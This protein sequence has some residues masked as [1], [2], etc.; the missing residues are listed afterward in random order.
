MKPERWQQVKDLFSRALD[1]DEGERAAFVAAEAADDEDLQ[2]EVLR[3]LEEERRSAEFLTPPNV[4]ESLPDFGPG[5]REIPADLEQLGDF[6]LL[7]EIG[8]GGNGVVYLARQE[9]LGRMVAVKILWPAM[10]FSRHQMERFRREAIATAKLQHPGIVQ[11]HMVGEDRD[12]PYLVM[13]YVDGESLSHRLLNGWLGESGEA[14]FR[15]AAELAMHVAEALHHAHERG[16]IHRDVKPPNILIGGDGKPRV[17]DFGLA[18]D[19]ADISITRTGQ[20]EGTPNYMSPEQ[21]KAVRAEVDHRTDVYSLGVV[22]YE[23]ITGQ[24]PF[25]ATSAEQIFHNITAHIPPRARKVDGR[26]PRDL[27]TICHKAMEKKP[28]DRYAT[29]SALSLDLRRF[30]ERKPI[31]ASPPSPLTLAAR[32]AGR[33]RSAVSAGLL[34]LVGGL[35]G[36]QLGVFGAERS[37]TV[38]VSL[39]LESDRDARDAL[40][41]VAPVDPVT[42]ETGEREEL[43]RYPGPSDTFRL[44]PGRYRFHAELADFGQVELAADLLQPGRRY[45]IGGAWLR[46]DDEVENGMI[47][48]DGRTTQVCIGMH[49]PAAQDQILTCWDAEVAPFLLDPHPVT[50]REYQVFVEA[51]GHP[52]PFFWPGPPREEWAD[53]PVTGVGLEDARAYAAWAGKRLPTLAEWELWARGSSFVK[54]PPGVSEENLRAIGNVGQ[55]DRRAEEQRE[56][57]SDAEWTMRAFLRAVRPAGDH[58]ERLGNIYEWVDT[59]KITDRDGRREAS[60]DSYYLVGGSAVGSDLGKLR[61]GGLGYVPSAPRENAHWLHG[62]RC[63]RSLDP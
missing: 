47:L 62:F 11:V 24:R 41:S 1:L 28:G 14:R 6:H 30:L 55:P 61:K 46:P 17:V 31:L 37:N 34:L 20:I 25:E 8:R 63:A 16:V 23:L 58:D 59:P 49:R 36:I 9:S 13:D 22:L 50:C 35:S 53:L 4:A 57:E 10:R 7:K 26:V 54:F 33:H 38:T 19:R 42:G 15:K 3:L 44:E 48:V 56:G 2:K 45:E 18:K 60:P 29:A 27:E 5:D 39:R 52:A 43:G 51:T 40:L 12:F 32:W 21:V